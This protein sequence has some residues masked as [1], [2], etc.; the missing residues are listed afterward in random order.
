MMPKLLNVITT[1]CF[2]QVTKILVAALTFFL[3][4][5]EDKKQ[6]SDSESEDEGPKTARDLL[7]QY[8][9]GKKSSKNKKRLEKTMKILKKQKRKKKTPEVFNFSALHLIHDPQ[10]FAEKLLKHLESSKERFEVKMMTGGNSRAFSLQL[11]SLLAKVLAAPLG[12]SNKDPYVCYPSLS[13]PSTPRD[14]SILA[15]DYGQQF[16]Y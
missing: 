4:K 13:S 7:V 8:A 16:C 12:R 11:S 9:T 6:D 5:D 10:D 14:C 2:S 15:H 3:G 1:T